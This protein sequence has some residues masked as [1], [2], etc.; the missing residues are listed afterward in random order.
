MEVN[1]VTTED[2]YILSLW[3]LIPKFPVD[4]EKAIF[5]QAG[6]L[7]TGLCYFGIKKKV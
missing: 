6:F 5:L 3:H 7:S 1:E 4:P 2:G